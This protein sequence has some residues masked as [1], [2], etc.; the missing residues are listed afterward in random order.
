MVDISCILVPTLNIIEIAKQRK[1]DPYEYMET[2][3]R[4]LNP[5][6]N[7]GD[8][9]LLDKYG[10]PMQDIA[11]CYSDG[12][13][14]QV[15]PTGSDVEGFSKVELYEFKPGENTGNLIRGYL[16]IELDMAKVQ[17]NA[18]Y[19]K[20]VGYLIASE[21]LTR[22]KERARLYGMDE[23]Y[24]GHVEWIKEDNM[25]KHAINLHYDDA[26]REIKHYK[27]IEQQRRMNNMQKKELIASITEIIGYL[28][29]EDLRTIKD[30]LSA[31]LDELGLSRNTRENK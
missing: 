8:K 28:P 14:I 7:K 22:I 10:M 31:R 12:T 27:E 9:R 19:L 4:A 18:N 6:L 25:Y 21:R 5:E 20:A 13:R 16:D 23:I 30:T 3:T 15:H 24:L 1:M 2:K 26:L 17:T 29:V 11:I